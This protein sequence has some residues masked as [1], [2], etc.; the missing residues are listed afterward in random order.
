[1]SSRTAFFATCVLLCC[2]SARQAAAQTCNEA[3]ERAV[4]SQWF[5]QLNDAWEDRDAAAATALFSR[6]AI[7]W[8]DPFGA[9][10]RGAK[11]IRSYW[12]DVSTGQRDVHASY[13]VLSSCGGTSLVHWTARFTRI[14]SGQ[15]VRLDGI[16]EIILDRSGKALSFREW[17]NREQS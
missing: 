10:E 13:E 6:S 7:Y 16:A 5:R 12:D 4:A 3:G 8:D 15:K 11:Q 1:M 17:W 9:P 14:P 2:L